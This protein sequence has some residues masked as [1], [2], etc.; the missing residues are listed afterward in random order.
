MDKDSSLCLLAKISLSKCE[1]FFL[2]KVIGKQFHKVSRAISF[3]T[4]TFW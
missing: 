1:F 4:Y 2:G 3:L